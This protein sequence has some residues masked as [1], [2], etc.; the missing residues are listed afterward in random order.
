MTK[1]DILAAVRTL[2]DDLLA[3]SD[4]MKLLTIYHKVTIL[5]KMADII[6]MCEDDYENLQ[7]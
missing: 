1:D 2:F 7:N 6:I 3:E 5:Y 4:R